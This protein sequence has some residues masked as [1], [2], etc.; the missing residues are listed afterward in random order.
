MRGVIRKKT[1]KRSNSAVGTTGLFQ[2]LLVNEKGWHMLLGAA[3]LVHNYEVC[4]IY[5]L[6]CIVTSQWVG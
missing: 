1:W 2:L 6:L 5:V 3:A 4:T